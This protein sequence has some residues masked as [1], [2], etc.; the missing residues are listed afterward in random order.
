MVRNLVQKYPIAIPTLFFITSVVLQ[1]YNL[2][3]FLDVIS[4]EGVYLYA[5]KLLSAGFIPYK[6]FFLAHP[7]FLI[8]IIAGFFKVTNTNINMFHF[9]YS[10][11]IFTTLFPLYFLAE[12]ISRSRLIASVSMLLLITYQGL[13]LLNAREFSLRAAALPFLAF[14]FYFIFVYTKYWLAG[15]MLALFA[16]TTVSNL[17][18]AIVFILALIGIDFINGERN[19]INL[20]RKYLW[21]TI[22]FTAIT[23]SYYLVVLVLPQAYANVVT[24]QTHRGYTPFSDRLHVLAKDI[25]LNIPYYLFGIAGSFLLPKQYKSIGVWTIAALLITV[26]VF[27]SFYDHYLVILACGVAVSAVGS[28]AYLQRSRYKYIYLAL[29]TAAIIIVALPNMYYQLIVRTTPE[30]YS[31]VSIIAKQ[32]EPLFSVEPM[33]GLLANKRLVFSYYVADMRAFGT[34]NKKMGDPT[35]RSLFDKSHTILIGPFP[36][37]AIDQ[38]AKQYVS[39]HFQLIYQ[40]DYHTV[41]QNNK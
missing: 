18:L 7:P 32:P 19:I 14:A 13:V 11:W 31:T 27:G 36:T 1:N 38:A 6:D 21:L 24:F 17:I 5:A 23:G 4:D 12:K 8:A 10:I 25:G 37:Q 41:Y 35:Y 26:F 22:S 40:D 9:V 28:V 20:V 33:Y 29:L 39:S 16:A 30:V 3:R 2:G 34:L 15:I